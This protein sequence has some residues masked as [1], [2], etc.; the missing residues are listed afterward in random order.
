MKSE[1]WMKV[2]A[3]FYICNKEKEYFSS[4]IT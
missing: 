2:F 1:V 3:G 4:L